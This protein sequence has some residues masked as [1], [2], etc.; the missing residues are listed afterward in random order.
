MDSVI[1]PKLVLQIGASL[2]QQRIIQ[3][4]FIRKIDKYVFLV[5]K[6]TSSIKIN[7]WIDK[8]KNKEHKSKF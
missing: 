6:L 5:T 4:N 3:K 7:K 2:I 8:Y 1:Y